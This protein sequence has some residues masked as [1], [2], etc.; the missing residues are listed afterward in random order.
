MRFGRLVQLCSLVFILAFGC[1]P[2][3]V[4][5]NGFDAGDVV[6]VREAPHLTI[7]SDRWMPVFKAGEKVSLNIPIE[8]TTN[9]TAKNV[10]VSLV[11]GDLSKFPFKSEKMTFTQHI[12]S[13]TSGTSIASFNLTVPANTKPG[14]YP[15][16]VNI[17]Y[18][19]DVGGGGQIS[20]TVY[21]E[22]VNDYRQP[23]ISLMN[24]RLPDERLPA[25][26]STLV[27]LVLN[28]EGDLPVKDVRIKLTGF[29][30]GL[31][32][33]NWSDTQKLG[34]MK[35]GEIKPVTFRIRVDSETKTGTYI[36][37]LNID[38]KD[39]YDQEYK[40]E[41]KVYL[42]V[43]GKG[44][45]DDLIPRVLISNYSYGSGDFAV[46]GQV[47]TLNMSLTNTREQTAVKNI[48]ISLSSDGQVF[49]PV[50][51]GSTLYIR[52]IGPG[53]TVDAGIRLKP[54]EN[55]ES[56]T[57]SISADI[58]FQDSEGNK[59][60]E[61]EVI[62][63]P[64][65]QPIDLLI[66]DPVIPQAFSGSPVTVSV[67]FYNTGRA[68]IRNLQI[69]T[70]GEFQV[71]DGYLFLGT[72]ESGKNDYYDVTV[73]PGQTGELRGKII[74]EYDDDAGRHYQTEKEFTLAV[75][76]PMPMPNP[77]DM[78]PPMA[79]PKQSVFKWWMI[80]GVLVLLAAIGFVVYRKKKKAKEAMFLDE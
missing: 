68:T 78:E 9:G 79:T 67:D 23:A 54:K 74:F 21:V 37:D 15:I 29:N 56:Q 49:I 10:E 13:I 62:S 30:S 41:T 57:Y 40:T 52:E 19:A 22:V 8:N 80:P 47:F 20:G 33:D 53:E 71:N 1:L 28:N 45:Q 12:S 65:M 38:C 16:D 27:T 69:Y 7:P 2:A 17:K 51:S 5:S 60:S 61:K 4:A 64:V 36:L 34:E 31:A 75:G 25:G 63:I 35:A 55:A 26:K 70:T 59:L 44:S 48:K 46:P 50:G 14:I 32:L 43:A 6:V 11:V 72:L 24:V 3:A 18:D 42:P 77:G 39:E 73:I 58:E 66:T 76:E